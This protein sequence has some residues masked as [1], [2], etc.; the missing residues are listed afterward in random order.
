VEYI[1]LKRIN[2]N[3]LFYGISSLFSLILGI[4]IYL[5]YRKTNMLLFQWL[6]VLKFINN[7]YISLGH[8]IISSIIKFNLPDTLW[9]LS[10]ILFLRFLWFDNNKEQ[11]IYILIFI[12]F[13]ILFEVSQLSENIPGTFD[14]YDLFFMCISAFIESVLYKRIFKRR[15]L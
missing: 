9:F 14:F 12:F 8:S 11:K 13:G 15:I 5:F 2:N 7:I 1:E 10:G 3:K 4:G 6:P